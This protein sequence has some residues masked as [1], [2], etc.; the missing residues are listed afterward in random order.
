MGY[1]QEGK[2]IFGGPVFHII[3]NNRQKRVNRFILE[4]KADARVSL[5]YDK[6]KDMI[7]FDH[8]ESQIGDIHKKYTYVPDGTYDGLKW[9]GSS[10]EMHRNVIEIQD[11]KAGNT[12]GE[13]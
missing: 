8:C 2:P 7:I 1:S 10:W 11:L 3:E 6:D 9:N 5:N 12:P 13:N 4:Y